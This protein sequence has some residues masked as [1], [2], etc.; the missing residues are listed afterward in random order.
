M[1]VSLA[2]LYRLVQLI[3]YPDFTVQHCG[4]SIIYLAAMNNINIIAYTNITL[5]V[6][7]DC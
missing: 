4:T 6:F 5:W 2:A 1:V 7:Y 3:S